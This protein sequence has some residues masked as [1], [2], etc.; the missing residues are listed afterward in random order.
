[1]R[2]RRPS[3]S[4]IRAR[5]HRKQHHMRRA[6]RELYRALDE[7]VIASSD[8]KILRALLHIAEWRELHDTAGPQDTPE[9]RARLEGTT[10]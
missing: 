7:E 1:M 5:L 2:Q 10:A 4:Q 6:R 3:A 9:A 8:D